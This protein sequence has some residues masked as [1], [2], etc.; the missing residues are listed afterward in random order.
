MESSS[1]T[2]AS[3]TKAGAESKNKIICFEFSNAR[4]KSSF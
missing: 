2:N 1:C 4:K 3:G